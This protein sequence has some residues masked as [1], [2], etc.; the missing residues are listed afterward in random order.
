MRYSALL[1][2]VSRRGVAALRC[3]YAAARSDPGAL[4]RR[5]SPFRGRGCVRACRLPGYSFGYHAD[6]YRR[7]LTPESRARPIAATSI[8]PREM[9]RSFPIAFATGSRAWADS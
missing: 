5:L 4:G 7:E 8:T 9:A 6:L 3:G 2:G 1:R